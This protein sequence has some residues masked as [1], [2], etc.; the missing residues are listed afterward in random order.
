M[1][2]IPLGHSSSGKVT[3]DL[4]TFGQTIA[5]PPIPHH[6]RS[7]GWTVCLFLQRLSVIPSPTC[8]LYQCY[9]WDLFWT[10]FNWTKIL[11]MG[12]KQLTL[13]FVL[14]ITPSLLPR[15]NPSRSN[16]KISIISCIVFSSSDASENAFHNKITSWYVTYH[17]FSSAM[18]FTQ[19]INKGLYFIKANRV[20]AWEGKVATIEKLLMSKSS[21]VFPFLSHCFSVRNTKVKL[22][23]TC[24]S[25]D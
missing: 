12:R 14:A 3:W 18:N 19:L 15:N 16:H 6:Q 10:P 2:F 22:L 8:F 23:D 7:A 21:L 13:W 17:H 25:P 20:M 1:E 9:S 5:H 11:S 24:L 4:N